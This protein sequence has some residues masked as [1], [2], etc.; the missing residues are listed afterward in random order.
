MEREPSE[1]IVSADV[2]VPRLWVQVEQ[3]ER[4]KR[5]TCAQ[6]AS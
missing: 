2:S 6:V 4:K 1:L 3:K 5:E